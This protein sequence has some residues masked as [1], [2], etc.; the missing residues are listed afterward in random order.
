[1][2]AL[3]TVVSARDGPTALTLGR[4]AGQR[5]ESKRAR[6]SA[7]AVCTVD[8]RN[9]GISGGTNSAAVSADIF[10]SVGADGTAGRTCVR[11]GS[12]RASRAA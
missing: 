7:A 1:M 11:G 8:I 3:N 4:I 6:F 10:I 12:C 9:K 5:A 2:A